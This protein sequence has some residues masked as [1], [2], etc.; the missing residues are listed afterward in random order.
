LSFPVFM[1]V[2]VLAPEIVTT[3]FGARWERAIPAMRVLSLAGIA[4]STCY[5]RRHLVL[6]YGRPKWHMGLELVT[7]ALTLAGVLLTV[8][9]GIVA[10]AWAQ[11]LAQLASLPL[12]F[13]AVSRL[14]HV[15]LIEDVRSLLPAL[16]A[17]ILTAAAVSIVKVVV[18]GRVAPHTV[19]LT[20]LLVGAGIYFASVWAI[21]PGDLLRSIH[22]VRVMLGRTEYAETPAG[23]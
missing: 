2:A 5:L 15:R 12:L 22:Y 3:I 9:A 23:V 14:V 18:V 17:S 11:V 10:V 7:V 6:A 4:Q 13:L 20:G 16:T 21:R 1:A 8:R 19:L